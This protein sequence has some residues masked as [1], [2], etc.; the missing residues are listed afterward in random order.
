MTVSQQFADFF[1]GQ[2]RLDTDGPLFLVLHWW[3]VTPWVWAAE[4]PAEGAAEAKLEQT[5]AAGV[6]YHGVE[7]GGTPY[8]TA[9]L[10]QRQYHAGGSPGLKQPNS[11]SIGFAVAT[12][13][14]SKK[15]RGIPGEILL[16]WFNRPKGRMEEAWYPP[17]PGQAAL[18]AAVDFARYA[19]DELGRSFDGV[20]CHHHINPEKNDLR[21]MDGAATTGQPPNTGMSFAEFLSRI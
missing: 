12:P 14:P 20:Y 11:T 19:Q 18:Q 9:D 8:L 21:N 16:P 1:P 10:R 7:W 13:S 4:A 17:V 3:T 6:G 2:G 5:R 15:P